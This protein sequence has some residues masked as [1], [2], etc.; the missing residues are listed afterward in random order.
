M[1]GLALSWNNRAQL[2]FAWPPPISVEWPLGIEPYYRDSLVTIYHA[3]S[4][5]LLPKIPGAALIVAD[6]PYSFVSLRQNGI[7][8]GLLA[9][10]P[11]CRRGRRCERSLWPSLVLF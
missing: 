11:T 2:E 6:V 10:T 1:L 5:D 3:D 8:A 4:N 9:P 7:G